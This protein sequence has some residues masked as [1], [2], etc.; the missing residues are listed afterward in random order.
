MS[1]LSRRH[2]EM[3][4]AFGFHLRVAS[5]FAE[6][7]QQFRAAVRVHCNGRAADGRSIL[8]LLTLAAECGARLELEATGPDAEAAADALCA[9]IRDGFPDE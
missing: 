1:G 8:D 7:A 5:R 4:N 9:L 3:T 6:L 2:V